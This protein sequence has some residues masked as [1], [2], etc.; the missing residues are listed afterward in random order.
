M[1]GRLRAGS[2]NTPRAQYTPGFVALLID[3]E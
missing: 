2:G 1:E 3:K